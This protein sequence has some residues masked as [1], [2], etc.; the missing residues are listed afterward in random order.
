MELS[1][2]YSAW[3]KYTKE[4]EAAAEQYNDYKSLNDN[5]LEQINSLT[6]RKEEL[7]K[8]FY[9]TFYRFI[10]EGTW[11]SEDYTDDEK[12]YGDAVSTAAN[13]SVPKVSYSFGTND[14]SCLENYEFFEFDLA[15]KT[16]VEDE[17]LFGK[18][19]EEV[20][21]TEIIYALD[22]PEQDSVK[23]QNYRD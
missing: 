1:E 17:E 4:A 14:L 6:K 21:I 3:Q 20:V 2:Y 5:L 9:K 15:D 11:K 10:Q 8:K 13:S 7:N 23:I 18:S 19:R 16:W 12:Y 22:E